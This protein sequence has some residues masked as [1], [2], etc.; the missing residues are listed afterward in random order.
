MTASQDKSNAGQQPPRRKRARPL[1]ISIAS[2][3]AAVLC[4]AQ[5][6]AGGADGDKALLAGTA[7]NES[8]P[9]LVD[10][11]PD[12]PPIV[13]TRER[14]L[15][16][17]PHPDEETLGTGGLVQRVVA[18]GGQVRTLLVTAG[19]GFVEGV[20]HRTGSARPEPDAFVEYGEQRVR[21]AQSGM[22]VLAGGKAQLEILGFPD[23]G[24]LPLL[25]SHWDIAHPGRSD[26]TLRHTVPYRAA[27]ERY[28]PYAGSNLRVQIV[29]AVRDFHP[30]LIA[31]PDLL[32]EHPD[33]RAVGLVTLMAA[34]DYMRS[35]NGSWPKL[36]AYLVHWRNWPLGVDDH[37]LSESA[38]NQPLTL[39]SDLPRRGQ[40]REC[41][42][43][44]DEELTR[45]RAALAEYRTQQQVVPYFLH[46]FVRRTECFS[47]NA[48]KDAASL[49]VTIRRQIRE[50][51]AK[52]ARTTR[53]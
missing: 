20:Q 12:A 16:L 1:G 51:S 4:S 45:K 41:L 37:G 11:H 40:S 52:A 32:D 24:L 46:A 10:T 35:R 28:L 38:I 7:R 22:Q 43:L 27:L 6:P 17:S 3:I 53:H 5:R 47:M 13:G 9:P 23:G 29:R 50:L 44:T 48:P 14:L 21:E 31:F 34:A 8:A 49:G 2:V 39:P 15:I 18:K 30:T 25:Y 19:D 26:T 33:H 42:T 36:L